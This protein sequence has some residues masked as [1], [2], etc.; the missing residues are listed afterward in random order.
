MKS[1]L[2]EFEYQTGMASSEIRENFEDI[3]RILKNKKKEIFELNQVD[4]NSNQHQ[5]Y[6]DVD[7][8]EEEEEEDNSNVDSKIG[9][10]ESVLACNSV[11]M[12]DLILRIQNMASN[13]SISKSEEENWKR[14]EEIYKLLDS[15]KLHFIKSVNENE[16]LNRN[17][18]FNRSKSC[19]FDNDILK[20][21]VK[22]LFM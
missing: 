17:I 4:F 12:N 3:L 5:N 16:N 19:C 22:V 18:A 20:S 14:I 7:G 8:E 10:N 11:Y 13:L 21:S 2:N 15:R 9:I 6:L 1:F